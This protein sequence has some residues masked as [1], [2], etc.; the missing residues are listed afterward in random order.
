MNNNTAEGKEMMVHVKNAVKDG[1]GG[2]QMER[3]SSNAVEE[4]IKPLYEKRLMS[5]AL[6]LL[7]ESRGNLLVPRRKITGFL[8][9]S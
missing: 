4:N 2:G 6:S 8:S 3:D 9:H 5:E 1:L 7:L